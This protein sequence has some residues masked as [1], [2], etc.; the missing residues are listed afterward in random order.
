MEDRSEGS[1]KM[2]DLVQDAFR[3]SKDAWGSSGTRTW[4]RTWPRRRGVKI[5]S[6]ATILDRSFDLEIFDSSFGKQEEGKERNLTS[7]V[8]PRAG[9][10]QYGNLV[11]GL[12]EQILSRKVITCLPVVFGEKKIS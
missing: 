1:H 7:G 9:L 8:R 2:S 11:T 6:N 5:R 10:T 4:R 3:G 12:G